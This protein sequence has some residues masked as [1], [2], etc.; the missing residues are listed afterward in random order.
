MPV[1]GLSLSVLIAAGTCL[2]IV[3]NPGTGARAIG[4]AG[5]VDIRAVQYAGDRA[6]ARPSAPRRLAWALRQRTSVETRLE[7]GQVRLD[8][9]SV[10]D[11]PLLYWSGSEAFPPL[12]SGELTGLRRFVEFGGALLIDDASGAPRSEFATSI[13]R[14][15]RR[16][17]GNEALRKLPED[18]TLY[19]SFYLIDR[20]VG[21]VEGPNYLEGVMRG[22]RAAVVFSRHDLG[23]AWARDNLG[24]YLYPVVPGGSQQREM[25]F[26]LGVNLVMYALCLD[27]KDDQ[28]HS[29]FIMRRR[30]GQP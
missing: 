26:R 15:I 11:T 21:R 13:E 2:A 12:S 10:F 25:A 14:T 22:G 17:F 20:P 23:G 16:A 3:A 6:A 29:P 4:E 1:R 24:N 7:P 30:A 28:V 19:R 5:A 27:Y 8:D 9:A 18:H